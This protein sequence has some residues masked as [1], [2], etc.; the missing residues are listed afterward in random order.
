MHRTL[1]NLEAVNPR[2]YLQSA[3]WLTVSKAAAMAVS[4]V[5]TFYIARTL[6][7]QNFGELSYAQS[8]LALFTIFSAAIGALYRDLVKRPSE[9]NI[10]LGTAGSIYMVVSLIS[11]IA[12]IAFTLGT[13]HDP[14]TTAVIAILCLTQFFSP[15]SIIQNVFYAKTETKWL[16][17]SNFS[18][19]VFISMLKIIAMV[20]GQ[21]VLVLAAIMV[22]EQAIMAAV[23]I[24]LYTGIHHGSLLKWRFN[25][26]YAKELLIDSLPMVFIASS[27]IISARIDQVFI[28][29]YLDMATVGLYGVTVQLSE[30]W[31]F[32]PGLVLT[33]IFPAIINSRL[34][35]RTYRYRL[36]FLS[37]GFALYGITIS[38]LLTLFAEPIV[39]TIYGEAFKGSADLLKVYSWS[40]VGM[41]LGFVANHFLLTENLRRAQFVSAIIPALMNVLLNFV[42][43]PKMGAVGA[44]YATLISYSVMP[45]LPFIFKSVRIKFTTRPV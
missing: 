42:L 4:L 35:S 44:A 1:K 29:Y 20:S 7:P 12:I 28:K 11:I 32:L 36:L 22:L 15:F 13:P 19:H 9:E 37:G 31:Q 3:F 10:L 8:L 34:N 38:T 43:I 25:R 2:R 5:A 45:L 40:M 21:G 26:Q 18:L 16:A 30:I 17:V 33:A 23:F 6:G 14:L 24:G 39:T 27:G 41:I